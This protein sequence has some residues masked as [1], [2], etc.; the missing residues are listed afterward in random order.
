M[1]APVLLLSWK[2]D[3]N[4][5]IFTDFF[6]LILTIFLNLKGLTSGLP[7]VLFLLVSTHTVHFAQNNL[8]SYINQTQTALNKKIFSTKSNHANP[9][10]EPLTT[11]PSTYMSN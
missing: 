9:L 10:T 4:L 2:Y 5:P 11:F 7:L 8:S 1:Y 6:C 3:S